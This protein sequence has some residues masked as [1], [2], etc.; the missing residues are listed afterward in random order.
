M[1]GCRI[2]ER[3]NVS[4][5]RA[6][7]LARAGDVW[8]VYRETCGNLSVLTKCYSWKS[9]RETFADYIRTA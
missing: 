7:V 4:D 2:I 5:S 3:R 6:V 8:L 1:R 9:A